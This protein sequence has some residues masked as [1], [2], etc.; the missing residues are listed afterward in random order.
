MSSIPLSKPSSP[1]PSL[2]PELLRFLFWLEKTEGRDKLYRFVV[3]FSKWAVHTLKQ[4]NVDPDVIKRIT[5]GASVVAT[6]RKR[7]HSLHFTSF[8]AS[9]ALTHPASC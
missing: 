6:S 3:Y 9:I 5:A 4:T 1:P 2:P 8:C 7:Q